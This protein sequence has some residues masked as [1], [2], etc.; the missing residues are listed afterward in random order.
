MKNLYQLIFLFAIPTFACSTVD[1]FLQPEI[2]AQEHTTADPS[3]VDEPPDD[4]QAV[5]W[6]PP[7]GTTWQWQLTGSVDYTFDVDMYDIDLFNTSPEE[8]SRLHEEDRTVICYFSAGSWENWRQDSSSFPESLLGKQ[9]E[10]W[11][12]E[13]WLDIRQLNTLGPLLQARL[14]LAVDKGC[15]GVEPDNI[16]GYANKSGFPLSSADQL[17]FNTWL[18]GEA[19]QRNL[20]IGLKND[21]DQIEQLVGFYDWA[22]NEQCFEYNECETLTPFIYAGKAVLGVE[23][24]LDPSQFCTRAQAMQLSWMKKNWDLDAWMAP[25]W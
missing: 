4:I 7:P 25:C 10:G 14:D 6:Q 16:D 8:I 5:W 17:T 15:D 3:T 23:Y 20:S 9:L 13:R 12:D 21:L 18:A 19:H 22:L 2:A 11:P 1:R 24:E